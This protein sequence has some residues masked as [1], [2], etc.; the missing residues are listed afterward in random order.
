MLIAEASPGALKLRQ[1][2][3]RGSRAPS[4]DSALLL[5]PEVETVKCPY[6]TDRAAIH[7]LLSRAKT[8]R[9]TP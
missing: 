4:A 9:A 3:E 8:I 5:L 2:D 6:L 1:D 7:P